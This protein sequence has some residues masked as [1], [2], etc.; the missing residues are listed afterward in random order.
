M[1]WQRFQVATERQLAAWDA[2]WR[3]WSRNAWKTLSQPDFWI[4]LI[5]IVLAGGMMLG[6][7]WVA[8]SQ[9]D[10]Y[11]R[12]K[13]ELC[14]QTLSNARLFVLVMLAPLSLV[15]TL[16]STTEFLAIRRQERPKGWRGR[17]DFWIYT[18]LMLV[19]WAILLWA[20]RC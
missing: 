11:L 12:L 5:W 6:L 9:Y 10:T 4:S 7:G 17:R 2:A 15:F 14:V 19:S 3:V 8:V 16:V 1:F 18:L 20:M 13:P